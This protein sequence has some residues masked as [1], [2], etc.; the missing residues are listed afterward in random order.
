MPPSQKYAPIRKGIALALV[1]KA[2][3]VF[4]HVLIS[5]LLAEL[6]RVYFGTGDTEEGDTDLSGSIDD[7]FIRQAFRGISGEASLFLSDMGIE[8]RGDDVLYIQSSVQIGRGADR[9]TGAG[10]FSSDR[11][12]QDRFERAGIDTTMPTAATTRSQALNA[13]PMVMGPDL[14]NGLRK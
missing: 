5:G 10:L 9:I 2:N 4:G 13:V 6:L 7:A 3:E 12:G 11:A 14:K 8:D 1:A